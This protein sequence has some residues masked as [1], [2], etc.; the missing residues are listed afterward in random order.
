MHHWSLGILWRPISLHQND[1]RICSPFWTPSSAV[2]TLYCCGYSFYTANSFKENLS[3]V[4]LCRKRKQNDIHIPPSLDG[5]CKHWQHDLYHIYT[6]LGGIFI[7]HNI[8]FYAT[9]LINTI[10]VIPIGYL[11]PSWRFACHFLLFLYGV[12]KG[13]IVIRTSRIVFIMHGNLKERER[14]QKSGMSDWVKGT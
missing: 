14:M 5:L 7:Y 4:S 1:Y 13:C 8:S 9:T 2:D 6:L 12:F 3:L 10:P 11:V